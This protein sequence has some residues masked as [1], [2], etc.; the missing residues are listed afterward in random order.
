MIISFAIF[1]VIILDQVEFIY[2]EMM[3]MHR[4]DIKVSWKQEQRFKLS[5]DNDPL[6]I[7]SPSDTV[8]TS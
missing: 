5:V 6:I 2:Y 1:C 3:P 8:Q 7:E 4:K